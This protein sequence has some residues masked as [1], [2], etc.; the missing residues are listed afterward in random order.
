M[1]GRMRQSLTSDTV[2]RLVIA[3][4]IALVFAFIL[5]LATFLW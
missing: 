2:L 5:L 1:I 4:E 3:A